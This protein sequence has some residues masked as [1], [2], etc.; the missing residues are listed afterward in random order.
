VSYKSEDELKKALEIDSWRNLS[1]DKIVKFAAMMPDMSTE[2]ATKV[3][4][5]FPDFKKLASE[6]LDRLERQHSDTLRGNSDSQEQVHDAF[7]E[8]REALRNELEREDL[9][10][11][12]RAELLEQILETGNREFAKDSENKR[13]L[14]GLF[15]K[16]TVAGVAVVGLAVV[17]VGG[18]VLLEQ[19]DSD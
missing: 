9:T 13:F 1:K 18:K 6:T 4:E 7:Q 10:P 5:H 16:A 11:E 14:S 17:F 8:V 3:L 2:L 12:R 15:D 19:G